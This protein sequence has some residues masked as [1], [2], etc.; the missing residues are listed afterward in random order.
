MNSRNRF[1]WTGMITLGVCIAGSVTAFCGFYVGRVD[2]KLFNKSS[3]V[4]IARD[5]D[6]TTITMMSDY[7]GA[8]KDFA[9]VVPVPKVLKRTEIGV[10]DFLIMDKLD[11][12]SAPRLVEYFDQ[13]PCEPPRPPR[14][15]Q[16]MAPTSPTVLSD[17]P[18]PKPNALGVTVEAKY[19]VAEYTVVILSA[20]QSDGLETYL[21]QEGYKIPV[22][23]ST[24]LAPY[25]KAGMKFFV[26]KVNLKK[27]SSSGL[28]RLH[29]IRMS[30]KS[31]GFMLPLQLGMI[32]ANG[33]QDLTVYGL[34]RKGRIKAA[35]YKNLEVPS[36]QNIPE[37]IQPKF[38]TFYR[39]VF[40][41]AYE[42]ADKKG[43]F[44]EYA[45]TPNSCDPCAGEPPDIAQ[46]RAAGAFWLAKNPDDEV[47]F[48]RLHLRY[49]KAN[50][51]EDLLLDQTENTNT[52]QAR[53]VM[54]HP[55]K[56]SMNCGAVGQTYR[57]EL[58]KR[59]KAEAQTV[60]R[61]TGWGIEWVQR[62]IRNYR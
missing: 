18:T 21:L 15:V 4:I 52:F 40:K 29:P 20:T 19:F 34:S 44:L 14:T 41:K 38:Q 17:R 55:Y 42:R 6:R 46:L 47:F 9:L 13:N 51:K 26:A 32:N 57:S 59:L 39:D 3:Q 48:T 60:T 62:E 53:Y 7:Q 12:Y 22:G 37:F 10:N 49:D 31:E 1:F 50:F 43:V 45:W 2:T 30:F 35:N 54:Q 8:L 28:T 23:A 24:A 16:M 33:T 27:A 36:D 25:I 61:L 56:G 11:A 58:K 5:G